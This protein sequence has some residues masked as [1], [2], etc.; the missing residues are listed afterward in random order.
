[1]STTKPEIMKSSIPP[2]RNHGKNILTYIFKVLEL[3][4]DS[5][6]VQ[7]FKLEGRDDVNSFLEMEPQDLEEF[8][9]F[10]DGVPTVVPKFQL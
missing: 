9:Y 1:M 3:D 7:A 6:V 5:P 2:T 10:K 8:Q 4:E